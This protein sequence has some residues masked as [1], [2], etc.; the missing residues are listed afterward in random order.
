[1]KKVIFFDGYNIPSMVTDSPAAIW[2][3]LTGAVYGL[4]DVNEIEPRLNKMRAILSGK[5]MR[6]RAS[7]LRLI[8]LP[9]NQGI[10]DKVNSPECKKYIKYCVD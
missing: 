9:L 4:G 7:Y 2:D 6:E 10:I 3:E 8:N 1:M 5:G